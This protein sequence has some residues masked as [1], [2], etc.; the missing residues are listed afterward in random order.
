MFNRMYIDSKKLLNN[1]EI[2][3]ENCGCKVC[4]MVKAN[5]Y[6]VGLKEVV[7]AL[8][9]RVDFF[10]VAC[11]EEAEEVKA[12][13]SNKILIVGALERENVKDMSFSYTCASLDDLDFLIGLNKKIKVHLKINTGMNRFGIKPTEVETAL[14]KIVASKLILEGVFTHFATADEYVAVQFRRF[15]KVIK[16]VESFNLRPMFHVD[17]S[18]NLKK[19]NLDMVRVGFDLYDADLPFC[20][21]VSITGYVQQV[22]KV[23]AGELVGY[24]YNCVAKSNMK[25]AVVSLGYADGFLRGLIG[26]EISVMGVKCKVLNV[27][28]DCFMLDVSKIKI[29]KGA[30][31][32]ILNDENNLS[33]YAKH[34]NTSEYEV[35]T[36]FGKMRAKRILI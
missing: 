3:K 30:R 12:Y 8:K 24:N 31:L 33:I 23:K 2:I 7:L 16:F 11:V 15:K 21:V 28:M 10:G 17:N 13:A 5:A 6:G 18:A 19:H 29:C 25:V 20:Q 34:L 32:F 36:N 14:R 27:C 22:N 35:M 1:L 4:A 9:G 26:S